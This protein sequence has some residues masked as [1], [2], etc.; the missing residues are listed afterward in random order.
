M[1]A[2]TP[3]DEVEDWGFVYYGRH[4]R[5]AVGGIPPALGGFLMHLGTISALTLPADNGTW[6]VTLVTSAKD[7]ALH[8]LRDPAVWEKTVRSLPLVAHWLDGQPIDHRVMAIAAIEHRPRTPTS[9]AL[10][11]P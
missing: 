2:R 8:A 9:P 4:F 5:S 3:H 11:V 6:S 1:E 7:K 10:P